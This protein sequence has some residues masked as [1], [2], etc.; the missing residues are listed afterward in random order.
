MDHRHQRRQVHFSNFLFCF[1]CFN[2]LFVLRITQLAFIDEIN[3][4]HTACLQMVK[5]NSSYSSV[6]PPLPPPPPHPT[7]QHSN[8]RIHS[9]PLTT[10]V[11]LRYW[12][13]VL[14]TLSELRNLQFTPLNEASTKG[15]SFPHQE[16]MDHYAFLGNYS[17]TPPLSKH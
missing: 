3:E 15:N 11:W 7:N 5:M 8:G 14:K 16:E 10:N 2:F 1:S 4:E 6:L 12:F 13:S 17:P 9:Q